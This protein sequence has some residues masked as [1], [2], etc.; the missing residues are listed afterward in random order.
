MT[1]AANRVMTS[2][3]LKIVRKR[4]KINGLAPEMFCV[5]VNMTASVFS[6]GKESAS[7]KI[8]LM[9]NTSSNKSTVEKKDTSLVFI[10]ALI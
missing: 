2:V 3:S 9:Q 1:K 6:S 5:V 10:F 7:V 8:P 4:V